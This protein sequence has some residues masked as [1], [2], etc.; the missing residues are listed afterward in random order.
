LRGKDF[1]RQPN[2]IRPKIK[3]LEAQSQHLWS[4]P[5]PKVGNKIY[6]R[7][8]RYAHNI[9]FPPLAQKDVDTLQEAKKPYAST[10]YPNSLSKCQ[11]PNFMHVFSV[12]RLLYHN[13]H[14]GKHPPFRNQMPH[15]HA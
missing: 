12:P 3:V 8:V 2:G 11:S 5:N 1:T 4:N 9:N 13:Q 10:I 14:K 15:T 7:V 6:S